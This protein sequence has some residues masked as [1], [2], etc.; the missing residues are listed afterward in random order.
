MYV[1]ARLL[2]MNYM[3]LEAR[4]F[5]VTGMSILLQKFYLVSIVSYKIKQNQ[6]AKRA[7][8]QVTILLQTIDKLA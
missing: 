2:T 7:A 4:S 8:I 6:S 5:T 3:Y 1:S